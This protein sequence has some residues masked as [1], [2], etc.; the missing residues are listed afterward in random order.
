MLRFFAFGLL[1]VLLDQLSKAWVESSLFLHQVIP[2]IPGFFNI[3]YVTNTGAAFGILAGH[4]GWRHLFFQCISVLALGGLAYLYWSARSSSKALFWGCCLIF[5]GALGNLLDRIRHR[6]VTDFL[7]L[8]IGSYHWPAF[9]LADSAITIG[10]LL[11][12]FYFLR[13]GVD[14]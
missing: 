5:G 13:P 8:Y 9:N 4:E 14:D 1:V 10:G 11:L 3:T 12:A 2:I 7:D 6:H